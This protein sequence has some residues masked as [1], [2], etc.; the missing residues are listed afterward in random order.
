MNV[1]ADLLLFQTA[2]G[3]AILSVASST[4]DNSGCETDLAGLRGGCMLRPA[5]LHPKARN[6]GQRQAPPPTLHVLQM[7]PGET[8]PKTY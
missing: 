4:C 2:A 3:T 6:L 8:P 5:K 1:L 7:T